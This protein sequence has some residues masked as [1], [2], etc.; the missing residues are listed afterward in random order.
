MLNGRTIN[1]TLC[2][3]IFMFALF[4]FLL[5]RCFPAPENLNQPIAINILIVSASQREPVIIEHDYNS[6]IPPPLNREKP[7]GANDRLA[8]K[9]TAWVWTAYG[10]IIHKKGPLG[11]LITGNQCKKSPTDTFAGQRK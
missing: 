4:F 1:K 10:G 3:A 11:P 7:G 8:F 2:V 6:G 5:G 9:P